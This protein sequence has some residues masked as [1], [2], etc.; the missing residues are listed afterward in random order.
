MSDTNIGRRNFGRMAVIATGGLV[1]GSKMASAAEGGKADLGVDPALLIAAPNT[2]KGLNTCKGEGKGDHNCAGMGSCASVAKHDCAGA[3]EC[4]GA[5][6]CGGYPGQNTC[7]GKGSCSVPLN[8][9]AW[10]LARKQFE[11]LMTAADKK[12]GPAPK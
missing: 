12:V 5:G 6:G 8:A 3:N 7:K 9:N 1:A 10:K 11:Q 4:K 2:C